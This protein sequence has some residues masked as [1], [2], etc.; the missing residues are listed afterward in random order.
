VVILIGAF[1][2]QSVAVR[3]ISKRGAF[4][5]N[6]SFKN[7]ARGVRDRL[8]LRTCDF[9]AAAGRMNSS[10]M[11]NLRSIQVADAR[12]RPLVEQRHLHGTLAGTK[13]RAE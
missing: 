13:P 7:R 5:S 10:Q 6:G 12:H 8:P 9:V 4:I 11:Q 1:T 3:A 2:V